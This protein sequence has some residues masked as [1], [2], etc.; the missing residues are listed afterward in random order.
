MQCHVWPVPA[1]SSPQSLPQAQEKECFWPLL[2]AD[3]VARPGLVL[4]AWRQVGDDHLHGLQLLMLGWD[5]AHLIGDLITFH[6]DVLP[7]H[8]V[9]GR[10]E[11]RKA[12][13]AQHSEKPWSEGDPFRGT[14]LPSCHHR[15]QPWLHSTT[16]PPPQVMAEE[17]TTPSA[18]SLGPRML[19]QSERAQPPG[20]AHTPS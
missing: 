2:G 13:S 5:G 20:A 11:E 16:Q 17:R 9:G 10:G 14:A 19:R 7:F 3:D 15:E 18:A 12:L 8:T 6:R 1:S 4:G